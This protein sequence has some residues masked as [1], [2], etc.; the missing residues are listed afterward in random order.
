MSYSQNIICRISSN[1]CLYTCEMAFYFRARHKFTNFHITKKN[2]SVNQYFNA[3]IRCNTCP[4]WY[5]VA[6]KVSCD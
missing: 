4:S 6:A 3:D 5:V 1:G 2:P